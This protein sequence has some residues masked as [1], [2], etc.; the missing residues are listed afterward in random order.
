MHVQNINLQANTLVSIVSLLLDVSAAGSF[1]GST[2]FALPD[3]LPAVNAF[4][5]HV[6]PVGV[7][8]GLLDPDSIAAIVGTEGYWLRSVAF[9]NGSAAVIQAMV[10]LTQPKPSLTTGGNIIS[11]PVFLKGTNATVDAQPVQF[12][13]P[14][15]PP[16]MLLQLLADNGGGVAVVGPYQL[17]LEIETVHTVADSA[18][19]IGSQDFAALP[20]ALA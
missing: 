9:N 3:P 6:I 12:R 18:R 10:A 7:A 13:G 11:H 14:F 8:A 19:A 5:Q 20:V 1:D 15:V 2:S 16:G 4:G 17:L